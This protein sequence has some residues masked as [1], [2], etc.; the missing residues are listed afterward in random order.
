MAELSPASAEIAVAPGRCVGSVGHSGAMTYSDAP[1]PECFDYFDPADTFANIPGILGYFPQEKVILVTRTDSNRLPGPVLARSITGLDSPALLDATADVLCAESVTAVDIYFV[2]TRST[3]EECSYLMWLAS[4]VQ[5]WLAD[6]G[7]DVQQVFAAEA[8]ASGAEF[9]SLV[10]P[11]QHGRMNAVDE[12]WSARR[13]HDVG[14]EVASSRDEL[15]SRFALKLPSG[16]GCREERVR[17]VLAEC[18]STVAAQL[19]PSAGPTPNSLMCDA[20]TN[21]GAVVAEVHEG[22]MQIAEL[23]EDEE[24]L[25]ALLLP[26]THSTL[27]DMLFALCNSPLRAAASAVWLEIA[28]VTS[29]HVR[30]NA[31]VL[32][33]IERYE[34]GAEGAGHAA[35]NAALEAAPDH[36]LS[37]LIK[38]A[39]VY[40]DHIGVVDGMIATASR[41]VEAAG[42]LA[43]ESS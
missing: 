26:L 29:D 42:D 41:L 10:C 2:T 43:A 32:Y 15:A 23:A 25:R 36:R 27:R 24:A 3:G 31:L 4:V 40:D 28:S 7:I 39:L 35:L 37:K 34:C 14:E 17:R 33:A 8:I 11:T 20:V 16:D 30:A 18:I 22:R 9:Q 38:A 21:A 13:A 6:R 19:H 12:S 5:H 1:K